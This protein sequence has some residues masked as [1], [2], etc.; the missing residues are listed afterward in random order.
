MPEVPSWGGPVGPKERPPGVDADISASAALETA[1]PPGQPWLA[2]EI[3]GVRPVEHAA[4][5]TLSFT[6]DVDDRSGREVFAVALT[7]Q[8]QLEPIKRSYDHE[9]RERLSDLFGEPGRWATTARRMVWSTESVLVHAFTGST[10]I[11]VPVLCNY[12]LEIAATRYFSSLPG[13]EVPLVWHFNGSVYYQAP[14]ERV[15]VAPI[16]WDTVADYQMPV[17]AW[18]AMIDEHY[19]RRSWVA[20]DTGTVDRLGKLKGARGNHT[21]DQTVS[22][23]LDE[24]ELE[25]GS[26]QEETT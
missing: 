21:I 25:G 10:S 1:P 17:E 16:P 6:L 26:D 23:L 13:G 3:S 12:D 9:T 20:L 7:I 15:Q 2:F 19:P 4:A 14:D 18:R 5:P 8:I 11:E 24:A 22:E